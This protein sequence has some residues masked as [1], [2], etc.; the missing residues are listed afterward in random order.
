[1]KKNL[2]VI[3]LLMNFLIKT[4]MA[5]MES[6][7]GWDIS[8][9]NYLTV[10]AENGIISRIDSA[11]N[12]PSSESKIYMAPG[13][14]DTQVNG[15]HSVSFSEEDLTINKI[16]AVSEALYKEGITTYFPLPTL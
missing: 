12:A 2:F 5:Q 13:L 7:S 3:Y 4:A 10:Y 15:Y 8:G 6:F 1:M 14:I 11:R 9:D 16:L